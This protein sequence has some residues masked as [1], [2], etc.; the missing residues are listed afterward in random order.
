M[1]DNDWAGWRQFRSVAPAGLQIVGDDLFV[2]NME[3]IRAGIRKGKKPLSKASN[4]RGTAATRRNLNRHN[5]WASIRKRE[6]NVEIPA[7]V[8]G[9]RP[10]RKPHRELKPTKG[11]E[12]DLRQKLSKVVRELAV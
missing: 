8:K 6:R 2:T 1:A 3:R 7:P 9:N 5:A 4:S 12:T 11:T 10:N